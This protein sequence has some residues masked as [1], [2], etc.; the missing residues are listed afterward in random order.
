MICVRLSLLL[1]LTSLFGQ[2][3][4]SFKLCMIAT[5]GT[6][7]SVYPFNDSHQFDD[8]DLISRS[9]YRGVRKVKYGLY[10]LGH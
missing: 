5:C 10:S 6:C 1:L 4:G 3:V 7:S 2:Q 9:G 8:L